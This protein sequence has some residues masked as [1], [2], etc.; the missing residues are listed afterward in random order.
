MQK[1]SFTIISVAHAMGFS[2]ATKQYISD[3]YI[4]VLVSPTTKAI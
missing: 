1:I 2:V 4:P 3:V